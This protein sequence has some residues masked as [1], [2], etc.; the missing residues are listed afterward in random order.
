VKNTYWLEK[1]I[2]IILLIIWKKMDGIV[3]QYQII[4]FGSYFFDEYITTNIIKMVSSHQFSL[5]KGGKK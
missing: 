2:G 4:A 5:S 3:S 1:R